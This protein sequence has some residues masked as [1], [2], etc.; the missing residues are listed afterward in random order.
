MSIEDAVHDAE[1]VADPATRKITWKGAPWNQWRGLEIN[2]L[3]VLVYLLVSNKKYTAGVD[4]RQVKVEVVSATAEQALESVR[5]EADFV[6][7][8]LAVTAIDTVLKEKGW[9]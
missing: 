3:D 5:K 4:C 8:P 9:M 2:G 6:Q 7:W 1:V